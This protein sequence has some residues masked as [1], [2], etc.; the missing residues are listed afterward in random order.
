MNAQDLQFFPH[1]LSGRVSAYVLEQQAHASVFRK[2][3]GVKSYTLAPVQETQRT[4]RG[5]KAIGN[6][7]D[8]HKFVPFELG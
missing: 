7:W 1:D 6:L 3:E 5:T 2:R 8:N 4:D